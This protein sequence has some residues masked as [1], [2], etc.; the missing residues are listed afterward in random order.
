MLVAVVK[1]RKKGRALTRGEIASQPRAV[2]DLTLEDPPRPRGI[3]RLVR[4][5][6]L[7]GLPLGGVPTNIIAPLLN[8]ALA[9]ITADALVLFGFEVESLGASDRTEFIQGWLVTLPRPGEKMMR[10]GDVPM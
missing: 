2:G 4:M 7:Y 9:E 3:R 10:R 1:L 8:P 5:A 6:E